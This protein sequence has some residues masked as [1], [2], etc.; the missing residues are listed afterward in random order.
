MFNQLPQDIVRYILSYDDRFKWRN[1]QCITQIPKNDPRYP[2]LRT[3][4]RNIIFMGNK[5][6]HIVLGPKC[7]L[8]IFLEYS[9]HPRNVDYYYRFVKNKYNEIYILQ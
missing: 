8:T 2:L 4:N 9:R 1:G 5:V 7:H 3:I 6:P